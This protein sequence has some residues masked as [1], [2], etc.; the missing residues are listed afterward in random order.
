MKIDAKKAVEI[1]AQYYKDISGERANATVEEVELDGNF[2]VITLGIAD[3][4]SIMIGATIPRNYK[5]F[6]IN[7]DTGEV[8]SMKIRKA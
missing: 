8:M 7:S 3:S 5:Q 4:Y 6:R 2:W 1:A